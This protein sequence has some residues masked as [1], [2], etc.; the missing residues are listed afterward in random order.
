MAT[1]WMDKAIEVAQQALPGDVP[2]GCII[3][4]NSHQVISEGWNRRELDNSIIAHAEM[5]AIQQANEKLGQWRLQAC[6][7]VVTLEPCPMCASAIIQARIGQVVFGAW[8]PVV[9]ALGSATDLRQL[10]WP[11]KPLADCGLQVLGGIE[12]ARCRQLLTSFFEEKR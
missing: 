9:G 3:L 8:D 7:L 12:E 6:T 10:Y 1:A 5:L 11:G 2:V 4:D